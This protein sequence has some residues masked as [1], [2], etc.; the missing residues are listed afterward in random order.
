MKAERSKVTFAS[1]GRLIEPMPMNTDTKLALMRWGFC[2]RQ[3]TLEYYTS[4]FQ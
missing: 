2:S 4:Q 3:I 1:C